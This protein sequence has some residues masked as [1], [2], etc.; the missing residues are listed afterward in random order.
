MGE[1]WLSQRPPGYHTIHSGRGKPHN[2]HFR[3]HSLATPCFSNPHFCLQNLPGPARAQFPNPGS[4]CWFRVQKWVPGTK[5]RKNA[6]RKTMQNP[7]MGFENGGI[8]CKLWPKTVLGSQ[9]GPSPGPVGRRP[10]VGSAG[11]ISEIQGTLNQIRQNPYRC[12]HCLGEK[13]EG[14]QPLPT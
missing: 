11:Q 8:W 14:K 3:N 2:P 9:P 6:H 5:K 10:A 13:Q 12:K 1:N 4:N 7:G